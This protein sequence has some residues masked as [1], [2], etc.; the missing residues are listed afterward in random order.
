MILISDFV[1]ILFNLDFL[2][3][4]CRFFSSN[5]YEK[6]RANSEE[7][8]MVIKGLKDDLLINKPTLRMC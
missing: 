3:T 4:M 8:I 6:Y 7:R 5:L 2:S 1:L